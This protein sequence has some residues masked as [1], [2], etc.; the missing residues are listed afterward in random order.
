MPPVVRHPEARMLL[1]LFAMTTLLAASALANAQVTTPPPA[2]ALPKVG[3]ASPDGNLSVEVTT[4]KDGRPSYAVMRGGKPVISP[5]RLGFIFLD[6]PKFERN[7]AIARH[8]TSSFDQTWEQP[9]GERRSIRNHYNELR[10][11]LTEKVAPKRT[12]DVLFRVYDDGLGF[13]YELP[14]QAALKQVRIGEELTEFNIA[15]NATAWWIPA[16]EWN[17]EEYLYHR[18]PVQQ[19][20]DAQTPITFKFE[21]GT[22]LSIH[23]AALVDYSGMNLTRV[24]DRRL[25]A[26]LTPGIGEGKVVRAAPFDT[27]WR[28]LLL[29]DDA[30]GLAM[31]ALTLNLNEPNALGDVSWVKP[32]KYV[33]VWWE[34]HLE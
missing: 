19:I 23:E 18:T 10:V 13:R 22:H 34:M 24:E 20:G 4:D 17:R 21:D 32:M 27:P 1:R 26:D 7:L 5:S 15:E 30:A 3:I 33:G 29:S 25:K 12:F 14:D 2:T 11:T 9:W 28:T 16:G 6:S 8:K 31:S